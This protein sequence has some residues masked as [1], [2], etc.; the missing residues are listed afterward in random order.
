MKYYVKWII[1]IIFVSS[2][3]SYI[4]KGVSTTGL[5][6]GDKAPDFLIEA[7]QST[8]DRPMEL[9]DLRGK[10]VLLSFWATYDAPSRARNAGLNFITNDLPTALEVVSVSFDDYRS[11]F[12]ETVR[13]D[14]LTAHACYL[15]TAGT[16]SSLYKTYRLNRG[17]GNYLLDADGIIVAKNVSSD[18]LKTLIG[19]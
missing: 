3:T 5:S 11:I 7:A 13:N 10:Y 16:H 12:N 9:S 8:A 2:F 15:D 1:A 14:R 6:V 17:F 19:G 4:P 18:E